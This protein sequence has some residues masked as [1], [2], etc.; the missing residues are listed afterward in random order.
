M[1]INSKFVGPEVARIMWT[2]PA[3]LPK[4]PHYGKVTFIA[5]SDKYYHHN[6][7]DH[8]ELDQ[9]NYLTADGIREAIKVLESIAEELDAANS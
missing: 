3:I 6:T 5:F 8:L 4:S 1:V 2:E 9:V 7:L